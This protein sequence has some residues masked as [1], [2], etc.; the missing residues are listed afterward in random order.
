M[1]SFFHKNISTLLVDRYMSMAHAE[2]K[3]NIVLCPSLYWVKRAYFELHFA[4]QALKYA[5]SVFEGTLPEGNYAYYALKLKN[6][7]LIFA[8]DPDE[9]IATL[10]EH[11]IAASQIND[12]YFAQN[13]LTQLHNPLAC[14]EKDVLLMHN[15]IILQLP[16]SLVE[17]SDTQEEMDAPTKLS[18]HKITLYR[19]SL[20]HSF[21]ELTPTLSVL[22]ALII[23]YAVQLFFTYSE[24]SKV[25]ALPSVFQEYK[26]PS[27]ML[28]NSSIEKKLLSDF[29]A[30]E[31][32]RKVSYAVLKLPLSEG[33]RV[34]SVSYEKD[35]FKIVFDL[36][37][38][39]N[40]GEI[41]R[42]LEKTLGKLAK[43]EIEKNTVR[44]KIL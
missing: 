9:I 25:T 21:K 12:V 24:Y 27:T 26:L 40:L 42:H 3:V 20:R 23:L 10:E 1:D 11:G 13:E 31:S 2:G 19:S 33:Q 28:Q 15:G 22:G 29:R 16:R 36:Q 14:N 37:A 39:E 8:Y 38:G 30:E 18:K 7:F 41:G 43:V 34:E 35:V 44:V 6:E 32:F 5:P 17:S 4:S